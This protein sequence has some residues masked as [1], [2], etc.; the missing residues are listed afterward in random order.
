[1]LSRVRGY[2]WLIIT[3]S[4]FD[5]WIYWVIH[6][7]LLLI[8]IT[9]NSSYS[10][11]K[12]RSIP[13]WTTSIFSSTMTDLH[14]WRPSYE[15]LLRMNYMSFYNLVRTGNRTLP[16]NVWLL[17]CAD[18][19]ARERVLIPGQRLVVTETRL[20]KRCPAMDHSIFQAFWL[21]RCHANVRQL[22]SNRALTS[23]CPAVDVYSC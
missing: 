6:L 23:R 14:E 10:V 3:G 19:L 22:R 5:D 15:W 1:V 13:S 12:S 9:Y 16:W 4:G 21:T 17:Y 7:Q 2:A 20:V 8:T 18:P 11:T